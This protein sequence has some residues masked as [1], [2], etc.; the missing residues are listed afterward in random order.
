MH[1]IH[2][3]AVEVEIEI[4]VVG[5][6]NNRLLFLDEAFAFPSVG[7]EVLDRAH[8]E[9]VLALEFNQ[10][11]QSRHRAV[12]LHD[13]TNHPRGVESGEAREVDRGLGVASSTENAAGFGLEREHMAW[14]D[15]VAGFCLGVR[16]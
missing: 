14:L 16:E 4:A 9:A 5:R 6:Q 7:D 10:V 13:L 8:F 3:R 2:Q 11:R 12:I 1:A 15:Q